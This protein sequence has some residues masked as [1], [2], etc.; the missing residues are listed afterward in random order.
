MESLPGSVAPPAWQNS[1]NW[2][3]AGAFRVKW[4]VIGSVPFHKVGHLKNGLNE[5]LAVLIGKDGQEVEGG[6]AE[7][8]VGILG[9][10]AERELR[11][12]RGGEGEEVWQGK[13]EEV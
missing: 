11:G 12:W 8:L 3:S 13:R 1:I 7:G 2:A 10:E 4:L 9:E 6:C 5:G